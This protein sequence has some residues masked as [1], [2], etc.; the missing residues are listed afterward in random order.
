[1]ITISPKKPTQKDIQLHK[2]TNPRAKK[3]IFPDRILKKSQT[4]KYNKN[5]KLTISLKYLDFSAPI[6]PI[7]NRGMLL[8]RGPSAHSFSPGSGYRHDK[9]GIRS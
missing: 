3:P 9:L 4:F 2:T 8:A 6:L 5:K 1:V 7:G